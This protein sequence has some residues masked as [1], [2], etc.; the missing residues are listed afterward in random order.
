MSKKIYCGEIKEDIHGTPIR[1]FKKAVSLSKQDKFRVYT[2]DPQFIEALEV[3]CGEDNINIY[4]IINGKCIET[5]FLEVYNYLGDLC[6]TIGLIRLYNSGC[7]FYKTE[8]E[9]EDII[10]K[11]IKE[12][13]VKWGDINE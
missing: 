3:L 4:L 10:N 11:E 8:T 5:S 6:D 1:K 9:I 2:N 13:E 7:S 12:Y